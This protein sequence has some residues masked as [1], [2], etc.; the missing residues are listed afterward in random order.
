MSTIDDGAITHLMMSQFDRPEAPLTVDPISIEGDFAIA[1]WS[2]DGRG[3]RALLRRVASG[4][5]IVLCAGEPVLDPDFLA[6]QG[7]TP[8]TANLLAEIAHSAETELGR[9]LVA[10]LNAFDGVVMISGGDGHNHGHGSA[11]N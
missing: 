9:D 11:G 8:D 4:W 3:G 1:G 5:E 10:R 6:E 2:Q 7:I